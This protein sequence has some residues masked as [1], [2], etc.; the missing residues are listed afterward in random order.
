M[1]G[2]EWARFVSA[3]AR[4]AVA[5]RRPQRCFCSRGEAV[6]AVEHRSMAIDVA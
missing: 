1:Y 6:V 3:M 5:A 2:A 4:V